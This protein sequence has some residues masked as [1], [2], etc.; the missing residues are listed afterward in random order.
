[1]E[2][3][4]AEALALE[5]EIEEA[6]KRVGEIKGEMEGLWAEV[7]QGGGERGGG[8]GATTK[9]ELC[10]VFIHRGAFCF[11]SFPFSP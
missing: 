11:L 4:S 5:K 9:Y 3:T 10:S 7:G 2:D 8:E 6:E 1:M